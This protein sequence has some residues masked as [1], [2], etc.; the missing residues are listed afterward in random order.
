M[1]STSPAMV[2]FFV[3]FLF[4]TSFGLM[5][6]VVGVIVENTLMAAEQNEEKVGGFFLISR[7]FCA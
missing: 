1:R 6:I 2:L 5:N 4:L 3:A 7:G